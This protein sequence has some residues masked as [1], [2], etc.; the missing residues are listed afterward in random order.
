MRVRAVVEF[1]LK[2]DEDFPSVEDVMAYHKKWGRIKNP[3]PEGIIALE[4]A[5][6][7][8]DEHCGLAEFK[9]AVITIEALEE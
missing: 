6:L 2:F 3:T 5:D 7:L 1:D 8:E 4:I 9:S